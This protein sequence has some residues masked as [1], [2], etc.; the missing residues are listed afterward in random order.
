[1][2]YDEFLKSEPYIAERREK[3][4]AL[5][6]VLKQLTVEH[7]DNCLEY[8]E[9]LSAYGINTTADVMKFTSYEE[10]PFLPVRMFK[11]YE[12]MSVPK[13]AVVKTMTS[14]GTSG[15]Q[16]S[17]IYLDKVTSSN[18][19]RVMTHI[20]S[21]FIGKKRLPMI[22][23]DTSAVLKKRAMF[24]ARGAGI[25]GFSMFGR[26]RIYAL[27]DNMKLD[28]NALKIFLE[29][30]KGEDIFLFGFTFMI[31]QHFFQELLKSEWK[32]DLSR[33]ILIHGGGWKK[34]QDQA[35]SPETFKDALNSVCGIC[36]NK[37]YSYYGM[38]EQTGTIYGVRMR[39][40]PCTSIF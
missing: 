7:M 40:L 38:V 30:Y 3:H 11:E 2:N 27:D 13:D 22:I 26:D 20:V 5:T 6:D 12:L 17:K 9:I 33:G 16:V 25:L 28:V 31:W 37:I 29:K 8:N 21:D 32:P 23:L 19:S 15:Q 39:T 14:S 35:V 18:Q 4:G 1:M 24:S 10:I 36:Q 34:L